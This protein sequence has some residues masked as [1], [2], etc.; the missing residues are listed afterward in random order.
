MLR[1][2]HRAPCF[3]SSITI[4]SSYSCNAYDIRSDNFYFLMF[5]CIFLVH[6]SINFINEYFKYH[7]PVHIV[8]A[9]GRARMRLN[10][11]LSGV[12]TH[13][14]FF[15]RLHG[16]FACFF[17]ERCTSTMNTMVLGSIIFYYVYITEPLR[18][19][20]SSLLS[21]AVNWTMYTTSYWRR[22]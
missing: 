20:Y 16:D 2:E 19:I 11:I 4:G 1:R 22:V 17:H 8:A 7:M 13:F 9:N 21:Y 3:C 12:W 6:S 14:F 15:N 10:T 18:A 5:N